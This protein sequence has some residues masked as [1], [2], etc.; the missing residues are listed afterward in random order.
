MVDLTKYGHDL[1]VDS[2]SEGGGG[3]KLTPGRYN[4][5]FCGDE[6]ITGANG[7]EALKLYFEIEDTTI[8]MNYACTMAHDSS[9]KAVSIGVETLR[10]IGKA[11]GVTG[12]LTD[13]SVQLLGKSLS[14]EL[15]EGDK[16]YL[17]IKEDF[18]NTFQPVTN[19]ESKTT[20]AEKTVKETSKEDVPF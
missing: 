9:D 15:V 19:K 5:T 8:N 6:I 11:C 12:A 14:A 18:G 2:V 13:P 1:D 7:W 4:M 10:K 17:E 3:S 16:G 20:G